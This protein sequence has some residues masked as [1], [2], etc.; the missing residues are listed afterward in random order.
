MSRGFTLVEMAIVI[1]IIGLVVGGIFV[2]R[3]LIQSSNL[4]GIIADITAYSEAAVNFQR[5]YGALP[6]DF[7]N[8]TTYWGAVNGTPATCQTTVGTPPATC[9]G[10]GNGKI[11]NGYATPNYESF[12]AWQ[13]LANGGFIKGNYS[14]VVGTTEDT[15]FPSSPMGGGYAMVWL[16]TISGDNNYYDG[17]YGNAILLGKAAS[18]YYPRQGLLA[19]KDA[20]SI[21]SK[22]DDDKPGT[23]KVRS[24]KYSSTTAPGCASSD[25]ASSALYATSASYGSGASDKVCTLVFNVGL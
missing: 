4:T 5:T 2:G 12:R 21:D 17:S 1:V 22:M 14:G 15:N 11:G 18:G 25:T 3:S 13:H 24:T 20:E 16:G 19:P 8:A 10:D 6:G 7:A 23:G 9:N